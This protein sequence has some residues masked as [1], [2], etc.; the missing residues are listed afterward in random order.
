MLHDPLL[1]GVP[2]KI[3]LNEKG[4][5]ELSPPN[6]RHAVLQAFVSRE[7]HRLR[8]NGVALGECSI[9]TDAGIRA[10]DAAWASAE[11]MS[12]Y[13][14]TSPLP[15]APELCVEVLSPTNSR[16]EMR[17]K[18]AAYLAAGAVEVWLV[19]EDGTV[20]MFGAAGRIESSALGFVLGPPPV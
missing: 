1:A 12:R 10:P 11:F 20:E 18:T 4:T 15:R 2:G 19:A 8:P 7:L 5:I 9:E 3:E 14:K 13:G 16:P 17:E 6:T